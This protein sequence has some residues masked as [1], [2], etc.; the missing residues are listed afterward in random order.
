[1]LTNWSGN[2]RFAAAR[3]HRPTTVEEL[4]TIV[5]GA[6]R[7][8]ALGSRHSFTDVADTPGDLVATDT[9]PE[10][11]EVDAGRRE[12]RVSGGLTYG[13]LAVALH[14][15]GWALA[16]MA[17]LPHISVAGA[18]AT[19]THGSGDRTGSLASA[20][21]GLELVT[22]D[23]SLRT[24]RRGDPDAD[25]HV[26]ALGALGVTTHVTLDIEPSYEI[27]Q[28]LY[29][30]L[31][32]D[33]ASEHLDELTGS[34]DSVSL[35]TDWASGRIAQVWLKSRAGTSPTELFGAPAATGTLHMLVGADVA[36]VT[37]QGGL[38]GPWHERLP[39][40]R[41]DFTPSRGEELQSE[42]L[43]PRAH[44]AAAFEALRSLAG[45]FAPLLQ[46]SEVRTVAADRLWLSG[47]YGTDVIA[48]HF[49]W[50]RDVAAVYAVLPAIEEGLLALGARP[51]WG[52]CFAA[53]AS[54]LRPL[55]PRFDDFRDLALR[56]DPDGVFHS[57]FLARTLDLR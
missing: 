11:I 47:A 29:T 36:A 32:W 30:D 31:P 12:V 4:Q 16:T 45:T 5:A 28:D 40:F 52:K 42:Y 25:G 8:H 53:T 19:G 43:V 57:H 21:T 14:T 51:H 18:V 35:F 26:V 56:S 15:R 46:V 23:G 37:E 50:V 20:V 9:L 55:Y 34:A 10:E 24:V 3:L 44:A 6:D 41:M 22:A 54:E 1:M 17:S 38:P 2:H 48:L 33:V 7:V 13:R 27:R 49:T 39:H